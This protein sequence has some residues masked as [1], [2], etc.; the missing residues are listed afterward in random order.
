[1]AN[2]Y[3]TPGVYIEEKNAF[4]NSVVPVPTAVPAFVGYT[5]KAVMDKKDLKNVPTRISSFGEYLLY[6]GEGPNTTY[7]LAENPDPDKNYKLT[8]T[9]NTRYLLFYSMKLFFANGGSDCYIV[10]IGNYAQAVKKEDFFGKATI[11]IDTLEKEPEPTMLVIPDSM[12]LGQDV[13]GELHQAMLA[14]CSKMSN[15]FAIFDVYMNENAETEPDPHKNAEAYRSNIGD[16]NLQWGA[17]Y[18][19]W[20]ETTI[21]GSDSVSFVNLAPEAIDSLK[22]L[23]EK[24]VDDNRKAKLIDDERAEK[25]K[26]EIQKLGTTAADTNLNQTLLVVCPLYK[27]I[28]ES[29]RA[30][31]NLLP[32][33]AGIAGIYS[34]V[35]NNIGVFQSPANISIGS[36]NKPCVNITD[37]EQED[38]NLPLDGKA[39]NAIRTFP[40]KGV[41][42]W[43]ART[44]DGNS[45]DWRY[46]SV[47]RTVIFIEQS[48]KYAAE[49][50]VFAPNTQTTWTNLRALITNFLTNVWQGGA[51]AGASPEQAFS[52][53]VGLGST[54]SPVDILDGIMRITVKIAVTRPA[55]FIVITFQQKMQES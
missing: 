19:P 3:K 25:V 33:S 53:D 21:V 13:Y 43:G 45:Q 15:R 47:R 35:D 28:M 22:K 14:H 52:V 50:Y 9:E 30:K 29:I 41:L 31:I 36:V 18:Y 42:V 34:M 55:E 11:G 54:M 32:P 2:M 10:S 23:L 24:E 7:G 12:L 20:L 46:I 26:A 8:V 48:I 27:T 37:E 51:L 1:M 39:I 5:E 44:L 40:G 16:H 17:A 49:P 4:P 6:F 38:L